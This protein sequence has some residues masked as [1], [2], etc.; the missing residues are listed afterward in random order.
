MRAFAAIVK[1]TFRNAIRSHIFQLLLGLLLL[2]VVALPAM[3]AGDGTATGFIQ[4]SLLY[5]LTIVMLLLSL[6]SIW[7][8]CYIMTHDIDSYQ[9]HMV[10]TKPVSRVTIWLGKF[11]GVLLIHTL[12]L[13]LSG[14][15]IYFIVLGKLH[16]QKFTPEERARI[17]NE[18]LVGRRTFYPDRPDIDRL[19]REKLQAKIG[20]L[21]NRGQTVDTSPQNQEKLL[22]DARREII[23][24]MSALPPGEMVQWSFSDLPAGLDRPL[25]LRYRVYIGKVAT[26]GQRITAG[27]WIVGYP[28]IREEA[29]SN[30]GEKAEAVG[31]TLTYTP[32]SLNPEQ[33]KSGD[34][35]EK[36]LQPEWKLVT[37][38]NKL[39]LSYVNF[40][41]MNGTQHFQVSDGPKILLRVTGFAANYARAILAIF[42][43]LLLL[44]GLA[45]S[46]AAFLTMPTAIFV[47]TSYLISGSF[48]SYLAETSYFG[49]AADYIGYYIG[50]LLLWV[51][52]P[53]QKFEV[54]DLVANGE[55]IELSFL[56]GLILN[57]LLLRALPFVI[58]GILLY[59]RRELGLVIRK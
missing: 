53:V 25:Y 47:V 26:E 34:F 22:N 57:Y 13:I 56:W 24:Q 32:L 50:K 30:A 17:Q 9:I 44:T 4:I 38:D 10:T 35:H 15:T 37:P 27:Q 8:S 6:S 19:A 18:V 20:E 11:T 48:A 14:A 51:I 2:S 41:G 49:G 29:K 3:I 16:Q 31:Y 52:I 21:E 42:L 40:D 46:T 54:T 45:C 23:A 55:L 33:I 7:L 28:R 1:L 59:R 5:S 36:V 58:F 12:L 43:E 39:F